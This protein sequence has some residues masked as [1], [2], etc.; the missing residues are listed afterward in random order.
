MKQ[1]MIIAL[2]ALAVPV[3]AQDAA[4][5]R[6]RPERPGGVG[7]PGRPEM[8]AKYDKDGDG[9]LSEEERKAMMEDLQ[10][11]AKERRKKLF[12]TMDKDGDGKLTL[13]EY[14]A[15]QPQ[16]P[17]RPA[18]NRPG[19]ASRDTPEMI[20]KYD[21]DGDGKLSDEERTAMRTDQMKTRREQQ[22]KTMDKDGK[23]T[24]TLEQFLESGPSPRNIGAPGERPNRNLGAGGERPNRRGAAGP[25]EGA[26]GERPNRRG[27]AGPRPAPAN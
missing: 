15:G 3:L 6:A 13:E 16:L 5:R 27:G 4:Q 23:G 21:K 9:K 12:E 22:F 18:V 11:E 17:N 20:A 25:A 26:G 14:L 8:I 19:Q 24:I 1:L 2:A 10:K 7:A